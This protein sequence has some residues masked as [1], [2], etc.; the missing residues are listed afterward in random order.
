MNQLNKYGYLA[1]INAIESEECTYGK[2]TESVD[3]FLFRC[4]RWGSLRG[5]IGRLAGRR[6]GDTS[7][8]WEDGQ[9][10]IKMG[11]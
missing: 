5:E 6:C 1:R 3:H 9:E 2:G 10:K 7:Y 4:P 11:S 8:R